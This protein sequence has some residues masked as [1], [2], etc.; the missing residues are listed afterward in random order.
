MG[1]GG[2][3]L[4][5]AVADRAPHADPDDVQRAGDQQCGA[6]R[7]LVDAGTRTVIH[8]TV[9]SHSTV[10]ETVSGR[11]RLHL[12]GVHELPVGELGQRQSD[13]RRQW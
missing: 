9:A 2:G 10:T 1:F 6:E 12:H 5:R 11:K 3:S 7:R 8:S 13:A 4:E